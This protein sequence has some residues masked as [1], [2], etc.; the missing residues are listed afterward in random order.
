MSQRV[1][2][3]VEAF[4]FEAGKRVGLYALYL[5]AAQYELVVENGGAREF[6]QLFEEFA[7][8][9]NVNVTVDFDATLASRLWL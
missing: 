8:A 9:I 1:L 3:Q 4:D 5:V 7:R 2:V 6:G